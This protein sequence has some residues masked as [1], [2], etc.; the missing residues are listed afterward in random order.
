MKSAYVNVTCVVFI[1]EERRCV[2]TEVP[3]H[4]RKMRESMVKS[5]NTLGV[6][7]YQR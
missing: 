5:S 3:A 1:K 6:P 7:V 2:S 4:A